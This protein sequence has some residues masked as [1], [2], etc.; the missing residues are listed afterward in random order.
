MIFRVAILGHSQVPQA[1]PPIP[2]T[3]VRVFRVP[4]ARLKKFEQ[5]PKFQEALE[6]PHDLNIVFL[7][8]ND[9][10]LGGNR[11]SAP[12]ITDKLVEIAERFYHLN[13]YTR[14]V[15]VEP[16]EQHCQVLQDIYDGVVKEVN[17][18]LRN[19]QKSGHAHFQL[20]N[21]RSAYF[22]HSASGGAK[23][24]FTPVTVI[25]KLIGAIQYDKRRHDYEE[26]KRTQVNRHIIELLK[27]L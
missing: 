2:G 19:H 14:L 16:R 17:L 27:Q 25:A 6:W 21:L 20:I 7:G 12:Q 3:D 24:R 5:Y 10:H 23:F 9:I 11:L 4:E 1:I 15:Y 8:G 22:D 13:Q 26:R 18:S